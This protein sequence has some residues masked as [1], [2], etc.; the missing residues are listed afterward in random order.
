MLSGKT[1]NDDSSTS[2]EC[3]FCG[4]PMHQI[5]TVTIHGVE[6][7]FGP[8]VCECEG[9]QGERKAQ[10]E[11]QQH[12]SDER[13]AYD[14]QQRI[15]RLFRDSTLPERWRSRT[16]D[17]YK[18][19]PSNR[20]AY[21]MAKQYAIN[22]DPK[23]G[24]GLLLT[25]D[26]GLGK[27][28]LAAAVTMDLLGK[29]HSV[30]FGTVSSLLAQIR[31]TYDDDRESEMQ[32]KG[33]LS[34]C[35]LLVIDEIGKEKVNAWVAQTVYD[36]VNA[37]YERNKALIVTTNLSLTEIRA[38]YDRRIEDVKIGVG[39][40]IVD[41]MIEMCDGVKLVGKSYRLNALQR[42]E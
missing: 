7:P 11:A 34:N 39:S 13:D 18:L 28:H 29:G 23:A 5:T 22:F 16:F 2:S 10:R 30:I 25:G 17:A 31:N 3:P 9:F 19:S 40:A 33:R 1:S 32:V 6:M 24:R 38:R 41:R 12:E 35:D 14:R 27:T 42:S 37:R 15:D 36:I 4:E 20:S 8:Y 21:E 26:V